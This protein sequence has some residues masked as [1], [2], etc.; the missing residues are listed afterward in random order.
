VND[1]GHGQCEDCYAATSLLT[2]FRPL[3]VCFQEHAA[4]AD[5]PSSGDVGPAA[6]LLDRP[7][8][9]LHTP[10]YGGAAAPG[11]PA[12]Q[13]W[14]TRAHRAV[15]RCHACLHWV[16]AH[17]ADA[18][19]AMPGMRHV[20][21]ALQGCSDFLAH[22]VAA[23]QIPAPLGATRW[24]FPSLRNLTRRKT[25]HTLQSHVHE[26]LGRS[27]WPTRHV[28]IADVSVMDLIDETRRV[29]ITSPGA[30][31]FL[32]ASAR[33]HSMNSG[34]FSLAIARRLGVALLLPEALCARVTL[35]WT[36]AET[37]LRS[38]A[39]A[40]RCLAATG[41][42][43]SCM[44]SVPPYGMRT[45]AM[46]W[47][48]VGCC[49]TRKGDLTTTDLL[50]FMSHLRTHVKAMEQT[51]WLRRLTSLLYRAIRRRG[52]VARFWLRPRGRPDMRP[53]SRR[54]A[55][56]RLSQP[57]GGHTRVAQDE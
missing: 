1:C 14:W 40:D 47:R 19:A 52:S 54:A 23:N 36:L 32:D 53:L 7:L 18:V 26:C 55:E 17:T 27:V 16:S 6:T 13:G 29:S 33:Y 4:G 8:A 21:A 10:S 34:V 35:P 57:R 5:A 49:Q 43:P 11:G 12:N 37:T 56:I 20:V 24:D 41:T 3:H 22:H 15:R 50:I 38:F 48:R 51:G 44:R 46:S 42:A 45:C 28:S 25:Q 9:T 2:L 39:T 30:S 31:A